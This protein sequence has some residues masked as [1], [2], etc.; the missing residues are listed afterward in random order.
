[1]VTLFVTNGDGTFT[2]AWCGE[3]FPVDEAI[4][5]GD[6]DPICPTCDANAQ[7]GAK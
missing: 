6:D 4:P 7:A 2:C 3:I 1:M 5:D